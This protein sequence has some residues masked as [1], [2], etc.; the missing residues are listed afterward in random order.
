MYW[1]GLKNYA[2]L[3]LFHK[4]KVRKLKSSWNFNLTIVTTLDR[5]MSLLQKTQTTQSITWSLNQAADYR[6]RSVVARAPAG[7][8]SI[9]VIK[10]VSKLP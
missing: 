10:Q 9:L 8:L 2:F 3:F 6:T 1:E 5:E 7:F 4:I